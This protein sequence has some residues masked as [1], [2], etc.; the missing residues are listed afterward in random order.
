MGRGEAYPHMP[1]P[2]L[3]L[4]MKKEKGLYYKFNVL[5]VGSIFIC[6][7]VIGGTILRTAYN[8]LETGLVRSSQEIASSMAVI[9][10]SDILLDDRFALN[11]R[12]SKALEANEQIRYL[13]VTTPDG[14]VLESTFVEGLPEGLPPVRLPAGTQDMDVMTFSSNEGTIR[15]IL[16]PIDDGFLGYIRLGVTDKQMMTDLQEKC[17]LAVL[18]VTM[19]CVAAAILA[20]RYAHEFLKPVARLSFAVKQMEKGNYGVQVPVTTCDEVG[21]LAKTFNA[22]S[23]GLRSTIERNNRLVDDLRQKEAG[24][25]WLIQQLFSARENEQRRISRELHDESSQ[26]MATILTYLRLL[27]DKLDTDEQREMLF[28]IRELTAVTLEGLRRLAV[29]LHPPLL[30]D[31]GLAAALEKY[32]EPLKKVNPD[33]E[34]RWSFEG[35]FASL[36]RPVALMCYRTVQEAVANTLKHAEA[37]HVD[38]RM[39]VCGRRVYIAV[40]DDGLGF[41]GEAEERAR[42]NRHL[43]IVSMRERTELLQGSFKLQSSPGKGTKINIVLPVDGGAEIENV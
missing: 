32:L 3:G 19:A 35:D 36:S 31:L 14:S 37:E 22:M 39:L 25:V 10:S 17:L 40:Q 29:D 43:G 6:G 12:M 8:S 11:E 42:L 1:Y 41:D 33:I 38:I 4:R 16:V 30:E 27:H 2:G 13:I 18:L 26:S 24:R 7:L 15:E 21:Q 20:T 28:E 34:L 5:I 9:V 23:E